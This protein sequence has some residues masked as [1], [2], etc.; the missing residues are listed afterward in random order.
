MTIE[1]GHNNNR[2]DDLSSTAYWYQTEPHKKFSEYPKLKDRLPIENV[3]Y[4]K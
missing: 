3:K 4:N 1:H 2:S